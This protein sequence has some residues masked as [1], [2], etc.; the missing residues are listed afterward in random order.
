MEFIGRGKTLDRCG[1]RS[2]NEA[3]RTQVALLGYGLLLSYK[4]LV[5]T[6]ISLS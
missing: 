5:V 1:S 2:N 3:P 4:G 6:R